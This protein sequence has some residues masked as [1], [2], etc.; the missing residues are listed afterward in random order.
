MGGGVQLLIS[1]Q[2]SHFLSVA[3]ASHAYK[4]ARIQTSKH[5][6]MRLDKDYHSCLPSPWILLTA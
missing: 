5:S 1:F 6:H 2:A 4:A 3:L